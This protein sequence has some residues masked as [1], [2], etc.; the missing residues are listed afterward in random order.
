MKHN[1][2]IIF[3]DIMNIGKIKGQEN[4]ENAEYIRSQ[5]L[6]QVVDKVLNQTSNGNYRLNIIQGREAFVTHL[7]KNTSDFQSVVMQVKIRD[8]ETPDI[9]GLEDEIKL[10][11]NDGTGNEWRY[12]YS[13]QKC[14]APKNW[15]NVNRKGEIYLKPQE[16]CPLLFKVLIFRDVIERD[17]LI[18]IYEKE[19]YVVSTLKVHISPQVFGGARVDYI[20]RY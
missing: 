10:V 16:D 15:N 5:M 11:H 4:I 20:F 18:D 19:G 13:K 12:W 9:E 14:P 17:V 8:P 1:G 7:V 2:G 6:P 3:H